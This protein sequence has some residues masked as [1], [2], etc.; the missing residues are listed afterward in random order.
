[1]AE[2]EEEKE[3][4]EE[5]ALFTYLFGIADFGCQHILDTICF[6][7]GHAA[8]QAKTLMFVHIGPDME[9]YGETMSTLKFAERAASVELGAARS[10]RES[11]DLCD[12]KEQASYLPL[13]IIEA[14]PFL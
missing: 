12:L 4:E 10:N 6:I 14:F 9:S 11:R 7:I 2:T 8:G 3:E 1:M 13:D 5:E